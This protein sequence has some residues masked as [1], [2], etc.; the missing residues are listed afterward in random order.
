MWNDVWMKRT[1]MPAGFS[2]WQAVDA[3]PQER[4]QGRTCLK[5]L[6]CS[7]VKMLSVELFMLVNEE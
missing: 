7:S 6:V 2:G 1:D 4:S 5:R 3:T